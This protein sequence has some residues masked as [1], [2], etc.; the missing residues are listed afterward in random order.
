MNAKELQ[1]RLYAI[2]QLRENLELDNES[3]WASAVYAVRNWEITE[4]AGLYN[5]AC[6]L[7]DKASG[8]EKGEVEFLLDALAAYVRYL[9]KLTDMGILPE[10]A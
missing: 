7:C 8:I 10:R 1:S 4:V 2:K 5:Y 6:D 3:L 9:I